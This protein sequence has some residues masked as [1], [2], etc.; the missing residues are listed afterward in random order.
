M[1]SSLGFGLAVWSAAT[2]AQP[3]PDLPS[4]RVTE[5]RA[6]GYSVGDRVSRRI[7]L[8]VPPGFMLD[9]SS[10]PQSGQRGKALELQAVRLHGRGQHLALEL[11]YQVFLA[12]REVRTLEMPAFTLRFDGLPSAQARRIDAWPIVV[13]PLVQLDA[14][15]RNGL[16]ELRPDTPPLLLDTA[17]ARMRLGVIAGVLAALLAYLAHVYLGL[18]WWARYRRP[19]GL[20]WR[21]LRLLPTEPT[22]QQRRAAYARMHEALNRSAGEVLFEPG[23]ERWLATQPRFAPLRDELKRFFGHSRAEFFSGRDAAQGEGGRAE[24]DRLVQLCRRCRDAERG[25]A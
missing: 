18:P 1:K 21:A 16:G 4:A 6:F 15:A 23:L 10:L 14:P 5:P 8:D 17:A 7:A 19:F 9:A 22:A 20:A 11:D 25:A 24:R 12:P 13:A 3:L 2:A